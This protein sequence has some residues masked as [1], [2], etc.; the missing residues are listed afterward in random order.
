MTSPLTDRANFKLSLAE[1]A[2]LL[3]EYRDTKARV[4]V[5]RSEMMRFAIEQLGMSQQDAKDRPI[6]IFLDGYL[7]GQGMQQHWRNIKS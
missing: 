3:A 7:V 2:D 6:E 5:L 1:V 4:Q